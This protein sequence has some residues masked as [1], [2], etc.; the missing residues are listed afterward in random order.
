MGIYIKI[1][2][3]YYIV[4]SFERI[5]ILFLTTVFETWKAYLNYI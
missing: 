2:Y 5:I 3:I 1:I 4:T